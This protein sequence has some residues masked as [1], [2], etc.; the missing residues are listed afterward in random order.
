MLV[1]FQVIE[2]KYSFFVHV[3][4]TGYRC[5]QF[6]AQFKPRKESP[7]VEC[8]RLSR[9]RPSNGL[10]DSPVAFTL[11]ESRLRLIS[12]RTGET[13]A[14]AARVRHLAKLNSSDKRIPDF[15]RLS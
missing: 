5:V 9:I 4:V 12:K 6:F 1:R 8:R 10:G 11:R 3:C 13:S 15:G 7:S 14:T 2:G